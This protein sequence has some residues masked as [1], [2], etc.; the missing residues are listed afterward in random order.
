VVASA[1]RS[2]AQKSGC[3][4]VDDVAAGCGVSS[5]HLH[6]LMRLWTGCGPKRYAS[7][8]RFQ[9]TLGQMAEAPAQPAAALAHDVGYFDQAHLSAH[10]GRFAGE[11]PGDLRSTGVSDFSKTRCDDLP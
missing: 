8:V 11:T 10:V 4:S 1:L 9:S 5:R 6:R 7:I 2:I 3:V